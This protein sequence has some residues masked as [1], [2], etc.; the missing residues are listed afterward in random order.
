MQQYT[1][2][3]YTLTISCGLV[4][5]ALAACTPADLS[6]T[7]PSTGAGI[8][9]DDLTRTE[10]ENAPPGTCWD[11]SVT[12]AIIETTTERVLISPA[13]MSAE[14]TIRAP[15]QYRNEDRQR[16]VKPREV[17][18]Y[19]VVCPDAFT[20]EFTSSLQRALAVRG[21]FDAAVTGK[22]NRT[23]R[24]AI[25]RYQTEQNLPGFQLTTEAARRLGLVAAP[26]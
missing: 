12:P 8:S 15:A 6:G 5:L 23:T 26:R 2:P 17:T 20:P 18:W 13:D 1:R 9:T 21:H 3:F 11:K 4:S 24:D 19:E 25:A 16:I 22:L 14:G 10:P 7:D